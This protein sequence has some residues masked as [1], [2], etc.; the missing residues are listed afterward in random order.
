MHANACTGACM[1]VLCMPLPGETHS[2]GFT[3]LP[4]PALRVVH[5]AVAAVLGAVHVLHV[6]AEQRVGD[7]GGR[8][9]VGEGEVDEGACQAGDD[10]A[11]AQAAEADEGV[12]RRD[13][14]V[15]VPV[16]ARQTAAGAISRAGPSAK[17]RAFAH[18]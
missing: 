10:V 2:S 15:V 12:P 16:V 1:Q 9:G 8:G 18:V 14:A 17:K 13:D 11:E 4:A 3:G 5:L 7:P 6:D